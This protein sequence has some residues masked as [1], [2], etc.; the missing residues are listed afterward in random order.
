[1]QS[2][3]Y[4]QSIHNFEKKHGYGEGKN[5]LLEYFTN[6]AYEISLYPKY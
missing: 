2:H 1:M 5:I 3:L 4:V 6:K